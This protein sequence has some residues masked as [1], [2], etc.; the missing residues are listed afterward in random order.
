MNYYTHIENHFCKSKY[1]L[2]FIEFVI[3]TFNF[4]KHFGFYKLISLDIRKFSEK[5]LEHF[6]IVP[7]KFAPC[8][9]RRTNKSM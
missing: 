7:E 1:H 5:V 3:V 9:A 4:L 2:E 8:R 6:K